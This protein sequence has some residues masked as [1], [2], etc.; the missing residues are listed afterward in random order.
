MKKTEQYLIRTDPELSKL[1]DSTLDSF[2]RQVFPTK[3]DLLRLAIE[4][5]LRIINGSAFRQS[6]LPQQTQDLSKLVED[7]L[8]MLGKKVK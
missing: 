7:N 5:G 1:I 2:S 6:L 3:A 4:K 8:A